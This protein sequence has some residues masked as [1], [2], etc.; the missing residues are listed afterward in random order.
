MLFAD[1]TVTVVQ[2]TAEETGDSYNC[3]TMEN[4]S[5][6]EKR[7]ITSSKDGAAPANSF[8]VRVFEFPE[9]FTPNAGDYVVKGA[10]SAVNSPSDLNG[11]EYFRI[12]SVGDNRR[13]ILSHWR[14]TGQ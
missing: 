2:H 9:G 7:A 4:A 13:G 6:F 12:K 1:K 5:W 11:K 8:E 14:M 3:I 10:I